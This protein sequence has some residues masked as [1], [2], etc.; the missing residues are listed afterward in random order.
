MDTLITRIPVHLLCLIVTGCT[1]TQA[2]VAEIIA[3]AES[4]AQESVT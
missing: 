2:N 3:D 4:A 1:Q